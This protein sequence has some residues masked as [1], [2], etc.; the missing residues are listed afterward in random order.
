MARDPNLSGGARE[1]ATFVLA[2]VGRM[3]AL[4]DD[5]LSYATSGVQPFDIALGLWPLGCSKKIVAPVTKS[6]YDR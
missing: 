3:S 4:I 5:M 2:G 6:T 1:M